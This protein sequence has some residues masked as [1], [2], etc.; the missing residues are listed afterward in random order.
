MVCRDAVGI[1]RVQVSVRTSAFVRRRESRRPVHA[2]IHCRGVD[3]RERECAASEAWKLNR[4]ASYVRVVDA[5][6]SS[7]RVIGIDVAAAMAGAAM[8]HGPVARADVSAADAIAE[9]PSVPS[10]RSTSWATWTGRAG[11]A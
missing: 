10:S 5:V 11:D 4:S 9:P 1:S 7:L 8:R 6:G 2:Q 3:E